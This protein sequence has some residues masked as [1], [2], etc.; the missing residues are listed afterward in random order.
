M[1]QHWQTWREDASDVLQDA[2]FDLIAQEID[3]L[4]GGRCAD[5]KSIKV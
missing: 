1:L 4:E 3:G 2:D 5:A